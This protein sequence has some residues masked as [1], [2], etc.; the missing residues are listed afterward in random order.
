MRGPPG[1]RALAALL[2]AALLRLA[3]ARTP[4][5]PPPP[6]PSGL[7]FESSSA[8]L[9][10]AFAFAVPMALSYLETGKDPSFIPSYWAGLLDRPA[11][12]A[13]DMAHQALGAHLLGLDAEN[14]AMLRVFAASATATPARRLFPLWSFDFKGAIYPL[15][16]HSDDDYVRETPTP[17]DLLVSAA[18]LQN[19]TA[20]NR[21]RDDPALWAAW[22]AFVVGDFVPLHDPLND[23]I[24]GQASPSGNIFAGAASYVENGEGMVVAGDALA[25][26]FAAFEAYSEWQAQL[27]NASGAAL[28]RAAA[29]RLSELYQVAW[30]SA[31]QGY[32]RG[33]NKAAGMVFGYL[34]TQSVFPGTSFLLAPGPRADAHVT[35][36]VAN[37]RAS[38]T[39]LRTYVPELLFAFGRPDDA[40][41]YISQLVADARNTYPEVSFTLV[42]DLVAHMLGIEPAPGGGNGGALLLRTLGA[43]LPS[44]TSFATARGVPVCGRAVTVTQ[45]VDAASGAASTALSLAPGGP[46]GELTWE[47]RFRLALC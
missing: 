13:R 22:S 18:R 6:P 38:G 27:G 30:Y 41:A 3:P 14:L 12:Y 35:S 9:N 21:Y 45:G 26:Q 39:E 2:L 11:F 8:T 1:D 20:D 33:I 36:I 34:D 25:K 17:F 42:A 7:A 28:T 31:T 24:A 47:A 5:P 15:D 44:N 40:A 10:A 37:A 23:G 16:Y 43:N 29:D 4:A 19:W 32:A 46:G